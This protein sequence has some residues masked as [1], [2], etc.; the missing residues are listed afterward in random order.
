[1]KKFV[2]FYRYCNFTC[3]AILILRPIVYRTFCGLLF[4]FFFFFY[5]TLTSDIVKYFWSTANQFIYTWYNSFG[6]LNFNVKLL[7]SVRSI[8]FFFFLL[9]QNDK[10]RRSIHPYSEPMIFRNDIL[11]FLEVIFCLFNV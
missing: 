10:T 9:E 6:R 5:S 11:T 1:M 2:Q 8:L 3:F 4:S 7:F